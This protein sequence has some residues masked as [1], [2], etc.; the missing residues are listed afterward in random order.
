MSAGNRIFTIVHQRHTKCTCIP[1]SLYFLQL[2][3]P[4]IAEIGLSR[5]EFPNHSTRTSDIFKVHTFL[6][7][8][9]EFKGRARMRTNSAQKKKHE[10][11]AMKS[12]YLEFTRFVERW[13][14]LVGI[15]QRRSFFIVTHSARII[16]WNFQSSELLSFSVPLNSDQSPL[17]GQQAIEGVVGFSFTP[18][19]LILQSAVFFTPEMDE[20]ESI[21][22]NRPRWLRAA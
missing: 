10:D 21:P 16:L 2:L 4:G 3:P 15:S 12:E 7:F 13:L 1:H 14:P 6:A 19:H 20:A 9:E 8:N 5:Y 18:F 11:E 22:L 17:G